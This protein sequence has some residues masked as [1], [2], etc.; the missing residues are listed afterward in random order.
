MKP[1]FLW[2]A[3]I[4]FMSLK[5]EIFHNLFS[6]FS[7]AEGQKINQ[8]PV[9]LFYFNSQD[10]NIFISLSS[11]LFLSLFMSHSWCILNFQSPTWF[12]AFNIFFNHQK[13]ELCAR[14]RLQVVRRPGPRP[15]WWWERLGPHQARRLRQ[16]WWARVYHDWEQWELDRS[17][18]NGAGTEWSRKGQALSMSEERVSVQGNNLDRHRI[19]LSGKLQGN[20]QRR[21]SRRTNGLVHMTAQFGMTKD[22]RAGPSACCLSFKWPHYSG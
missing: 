11:I 8:N 5:Y 16:F 22:S 12:L 3:I 6:Y 7:L 10:I 18:G 14:A 15:I 17:Q 2:K 9:I 4:G 1:L 20:R 21:A 13:H 19:H